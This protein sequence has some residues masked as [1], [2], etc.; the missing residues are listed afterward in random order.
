MRNLFLIATLFLTVKAMAAVPSQPAAPV[1]FNG[2]C[3]SG[4]Y[5]IPAAAC[6]STGG[7]GV[8]SVFGRTGV[9]VAT[10]GDYTGLQIPITGYLSTT[11]TVLATDS[12]SAAIS[13]LNGNTLA[14]V[15]GVSSF[16][17][18][19]GAI[20]P[21][22]G[23][24]SSFYPL[25][26]GGS[27]IQSSA[28]GTV[29]LVIKQFSGG[30]ISAHQLEFRDHL[31]NLSGWVDNLGSTLTM[32]EINAS[33]IA[34]SGNIHVI[35]VDNSALIKLVS[36][37]YHQIFNWSNGI[38]NSPTDGTTQ[39]ATFGASLPSG[40]LGINMP[41]IQVDSIFNASQK[42][43][44]VANDQL[45]GN[46]GT[47]STTT[48]D[49]GYARFYGNDNEVIAD[50]RTAVG[51]WN[52]Y[53]SDLNI[54]SNTNLGYL[55][56]SDASSFNS[57][58]YATEL[59]WPGSIT[60]NS[61]GGANSL[62]MSGIHDNGLGTSFTY[63]VAVDGNSRQEINCSDDDTTTFNPGDSLTGRLSA[64]VVVVVNDNVG[65][66]SDVIVQTSGVALLQSEYL[67][68]TTSGGSCHVVTA[69]PQGSSFTYD[70]GSGPGLTHVAPGVNIPMP[71]DNTGF[72]I[73]WS[74]IDL[75]IIGDN[76]VSVGET[77]VSGVFTQ[78]LN[79]GLLSNGDA[80]QIGGSSLIQQ[81][82]FISQIGMVAKKI[83]MSKVTNYDGQD[84]VLSGLTKE[85]IVKDYIG[86]TGDLAP[87]T[88]LTKP[89]GD[90]R[91]SVWSYLTVRSIGTGTMDLDIQYVDPVGSVNHLLKTVSFTSQGPNEIALGSSEIF[92]LDNNNISISTTGTA[93]SGSPQYDLHI[94]LKQED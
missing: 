74:S 51:T 10:T 63:T 79:Q 14:L 8:T 2:S 61:S 85:I 54:N 35:D 13:K 47:G 73:T 57:L 20:T 39:I 3:S 25:L 66:G 93:V 34:T 42:G 53:T 50:F 18:R 75:N 62:T 5:S 11:G 69:T 56:Y 46:A 4:I 7:G 15:T 83:I 49:Y 24:Y 33:T 88:L 38:V 81:N 58:Q 30:G 26:A 70:L 41:S 44:D 23:D 77:D 28:I 91:Y 27:T 31:N 71:L 80:D 43:I 19:T 6:L 68:N 89:A 94:I 72:Y 90:H 12:V 21:V 37:G 16:N 67:D 55:R 48:F 40:V 78:R 60:F 86:L 17:S 52:F 36:A 1:F 59:T 87:V 29:N 84:L 76:W 32:S 45:H 82:I 64:A 9:V 65:D 92:N 22:V